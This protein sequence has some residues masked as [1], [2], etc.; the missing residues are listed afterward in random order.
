V[1]PRVGLHLL[2][3]RSTVVLTD[4]HIAGLR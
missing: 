1:W 4:S 3:S 2:A